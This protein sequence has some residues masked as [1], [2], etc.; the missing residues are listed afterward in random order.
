MKF[1]SKYCMYLYFLLK[2]LT[3]E[4]YNSFFVEIILIKN[5]SDRKLA[6]R[7]CFMD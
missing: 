2:D 3:V 4:I 1:F 5:V 6:L 7:V